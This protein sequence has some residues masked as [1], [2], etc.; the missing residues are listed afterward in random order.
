MTQPC[1]F[2]MTQIQASINWHRHVGLTAQ[3]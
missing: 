1:V 2:A 3:N